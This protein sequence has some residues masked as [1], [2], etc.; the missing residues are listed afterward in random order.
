MILRRGSIAGVRTAR[1]SPI[2][3]VGT[4]LVGL[5]PGD[6]VEVKLDGEPHPVEAEVAIAP[7]QLVPGSSVKPSGLAARLISRGPLPGARKDA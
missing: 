5:Q 2:R 3:F 1:N 7:E 4:A 6:R